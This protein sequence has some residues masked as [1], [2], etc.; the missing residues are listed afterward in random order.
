[1]HEEMADQLLDF[2]REQTKK[3]E[4]LG[5]PI[6]HVAGGPPANLGG[7]AERRRAYAQVGDDRP[8]GQVALPALRIELVQHLAGPVARDTEVQ[9]VGVDPPALSVVRR[10]RTPCVVEQPVTQLRT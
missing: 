5:T 2:M 3:L 7:K 1:M 8:A 6:P 4:M 9:A 10:R